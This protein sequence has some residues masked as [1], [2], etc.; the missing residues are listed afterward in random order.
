MFL[1][2]IVQWFQTYSPIANICIDITVFI[3]LYWIPYCEILNALQQLLGTVSM[4]IV[5]Q[6]MF[7][8]YIYKINTFE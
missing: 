5:A 7:N 4:H 6:R 8:V 3:L 2:N 1:I